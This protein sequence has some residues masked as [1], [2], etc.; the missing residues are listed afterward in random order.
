MGRPPIDPELEALIVS[1][2]EANRSW[3]YDRIVG[4]LKVLGYKVSDQTVGNVLRRHGLPPSLGR[5]PK[6]SWAE[7]IARHEDTI[8]AAD[9]FTAEVITPAGLICFYV[10]FPKAAAEDQPEPAAS[11]SCPENASSEREIGSGE[12]VCQERLGGLLR[13]YTRNVG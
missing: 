6:L 5:K 2:A 10:L 3:G 7:F 8:V 11:G 13:Y 4:A 12:I 9:F 1:I